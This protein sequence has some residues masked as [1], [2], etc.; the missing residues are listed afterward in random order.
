MPG[1]RAC[2]PSEASPSCRT[3]RMCFT[4]GAPPS[5]AAPASGDTLAVPVVLPVVP[6]VVPPVAR[7]C[8]GRSA[9]I[10]A[11]RGQELRVRQPLPPA[12]RHRRRDGRDEAQRHGQET[13]SRTGGGGPRQHQRLPLP[14]LGCKGPSLVSGR[15]ARGVKP[16]A[17]EARAPARE[18]LGCRSAPL[19]RQAAGVHPAWHGRGGEPLTRGA[20]RDL[21]ASLGRRTTSS[22]RFNLEKWA[23]PLGDLNFQRAFWSE[24]EQWFLDLR[25]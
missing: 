16:S 15:R 24:H 18:T 4:S 12:L 25:P 22:Q 10:P 20:P 1:G 3:A 11:P 19:R 17:A 13:W 14:A 21:R 7:A 5:H 2:S 9:R 23:Q 6:P 8:A